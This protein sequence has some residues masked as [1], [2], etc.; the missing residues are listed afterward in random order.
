MGLR[1]LI[2]PFFK[3]HPWLAGEVLLLIGGCALWW[4]LRPSV[5][6]KAEIYSRQGDH[7]AAVNILR[8]A[9]DDSP[10]NPFKELSLR[11]LLGQEYLK[12]GAI[13][14]A[15]R[16]FRLIVEKFP[17]SSAGF[18]GLGAVY[19]L[20]DQNQFAL[21]ALENARRLDKQDLSIPLAL[22]GLYER[23]GL[24]ES[25]LVEYLAAKRVDAGDRRVLR[26]LGAG[27]LK[28]GMYGEA[29]KE[30]TTARHLLLADERTRYLLAETLWESGQVLAAEQEARDMLTHRPASWE[31]GLLVATICR[32]TGR[33]QEAESL[34]E[35]MWLADR[36]RLPL[37]IVL[38]EL[39][40]LRG[41]TNSAQ[42][43][44]DELG[45]ILPP[46]SGYSDFVQF[47]SAMEMIDHLDYVE[48]VRRLHRDWFLAQARIAQWNQRFD[49]ARRQVHQAISVGG[50]SVEALRLAT[51]IA[52]LSGDQ[53]ER[54]SCSERALQAFPHHPLAMLDRADFLL[55]R[56][57]VEESERL[58]AQ[59][60]LSAPGLPRAQAFHALIFQ[61]MGK[62]AE[63]Q[64]ELDLAIA[65]GAQDAQAQYLI[66]VTQS[67]R[68]LDSAAEAHLQASLALQGEYAPALRALAKLVLKRGDRNYYD[69]IIS[70]ARRSEP[71]I[72]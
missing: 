68:G 17:Q 38:A 65:N 59:A 62:L 4:G 30:L 15:E 57:D 46:L 26:A 6:E 67:L 16:E 55:S 19:V 58:I 43:L 21:E 31:A 42:R 51:E 71:N 47:A 5:Y 37:A 41:D 64:G 69:A 70:R 45:Q 33:R 11:T 34:L 20:R 7:G 3:Q 50:K 48:G 2:P 28:Q 54:G 24:W 27:Y 60:L 9:V 44:M 53:G 36:R 32:Q 35:K 18:K 29:L 66:G 56:G 13:E 23:K 10:R 1:R 25:A 63:S 49:E 40:A 61:K 39:Q 52:R 14:N 8:K 12:K 22:G 72:N